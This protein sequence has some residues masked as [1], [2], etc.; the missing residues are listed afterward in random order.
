KQETY[1][2]SRAELRDAARASFLHKKKKELLDNDQLQQ[3]WVLLEKSVPVDNQ[4]MDYSDFKRIASLLDSHEARKYFDPCVFAKLLNGNKE[5]RVSISDFFNYVMR[6][7]WYQEKRIELSFYNVDGSGYLRENGLQNYILELMPTLTKIQDL[8]TSLHPF[9]LCVA[10]RKFFFFLDPHHSEKIKILDILESGFLDELLELRNANLVKT[11]EE[12]NWFS[13]SNV[14]RLYSQYIN[15]D[16]DQNGMLSKAEFSKFGNSCLSPLFVDRIFEEF[17]TYDGEIDF[18][19]FVDFIL[20][21]EN[22]KEPQSLNIF[23]RLLDIN[24]K[25]YIDSFVFKVFFKSLEE[26]LREQG[27]DL[28]NFTDICSEIFDMVKPVHQYRITLK[29][30]IASGEGDIVVSIV[31]DCNGFWAYENRECVLLDTQE[32]AEV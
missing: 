7:V 28:L 2:E 31:S 13:S 12:T 9:Y 21:M 4:T 26:K 29:D 17:I 16:E 20:M 5:G 24:Q 8:D 3:L 22:K 18:K 27:H 6:K 32:E 23:F 10:A 25:G 1:N 14:L 19:S 30:L 15:L 11:R